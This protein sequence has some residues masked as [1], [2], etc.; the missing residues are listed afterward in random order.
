MKS[1]FGHKIQEVNKRNTNKEAGSLKNP[2]F[3]CY[4]STR[5][6]LMT[7]QEGSESAKR[8]LQNG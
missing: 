1:Q 5:E 7:Q 2:I 6:T 4:N 8:Y 3:R